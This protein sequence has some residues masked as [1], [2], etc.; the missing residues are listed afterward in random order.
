MIVFNDDILMCSNNEEEHAKH[1]I[2][3][4]ILLR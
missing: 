3:L 2:E 1:L 4:L